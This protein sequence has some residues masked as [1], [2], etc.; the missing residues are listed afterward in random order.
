[1]DYSPPGSSVHGISQA[2]IL[3]WGAIFFSRGSSQCRNQTQVSCIA[4]KFFTNWISFLK[5][6]YHMTFISLIFHFWRVQASFVECAIFCIVLIISLWLDPCQTPWQEH[7]LGDAVYFLYI[8]SR[9]TQ[10]QQVLILWRLKFDKFLKV[11]GTILPIL[12]VSFSYCN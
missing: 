11:M 1:M 7:Y 10:C 3:E 4:G 5:S 6:G 12:K 8:T 9:G 2:R